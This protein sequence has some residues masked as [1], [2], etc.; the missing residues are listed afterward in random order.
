MTVQSA[1]P[2]AAPG[3]GKAARGWVKRLLLL[4]ESPIGMV[5]AFLVLFWIV[6]AILAPV[7]SP[8]DPNVNDYDLAAAPSA[9]P[10]DT[11]ATPPADQSTAVPAEPSTAAPAD[12]GT[13]SP[14]ADT[15]NP[16]YGT[17]PAD[18]ATEGQ[19]YLGPSAK[20]WLGVDN[21]HR[22]LLSRLIWGSRTVLTVAPVA[23]LFAYIVGC[24]MG[25][26]AG[27]YRGW[28]DT[29][30][31]RIADII[32]SFPVIVLYIIIIAKFGPSVANIIIAVTFIAAP[33]IARIVRGLTL[34]LREKDYVAAAKM[35]GEPA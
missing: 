16:S 25:L 28:V 22:D 7:L 34:E 24:V 4:R 12:N 5:G 3:R 27:Y 10:P 6:V 23:V 15:S 26:L 13:A 32:L 19:P 9:T 1:S 30:L 8:Y 14:G 2:M 20:H 35:R 17:A 31:M 18:E 21:S 11:V 29:L 33:Q